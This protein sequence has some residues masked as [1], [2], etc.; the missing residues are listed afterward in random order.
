MKHKKTQIDANYIRNVLFGAEDSLTSTVGFLF[1][2]ASAP[3]YTSKLIIIAGVVLITVEALSMGMGV[4]LSEGEVQLMEH[5]KSLHHSPFI[6]GVLMFLSYILFGMLVLA[7]Y[8]LLNAATARYASMGITLIALF[9][10][11]YIPTRKLKMGF[12]MFFLTGITILVG[13]L[14]AKAV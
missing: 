12:K 6:A 14:V 8:F 11:G 4:Y 5:Q 10:I 3:D 1:G 7:P 13:Y 9:L 2:L